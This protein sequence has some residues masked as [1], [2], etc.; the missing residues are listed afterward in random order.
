MKMT[1]RGYGGFGLL[2]FLGFLYFRFH[3]PMF[4]PFFSLF[5]L[6]SFF[7]WGKISFHTKDENYYTQ[8]SKAYMISLRIGF[9]AIFVTMMFVN[10]IARS[11]SG[12]TKYAILVTLISIIF[13]ISIILHSWLLNKYLK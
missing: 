3:D 7:Y 9:S 8:Q 5:S 10:F 2:G 11:A 13:S 6:F 4:L 1:Q 12:D